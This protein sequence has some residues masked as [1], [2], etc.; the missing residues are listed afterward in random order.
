MQKETQRVA[1][2]RIAFPG[3]EGTSVEKWWEMEAISAGSGLRKRRG[4]C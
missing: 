3:M 1:A 2:R 4:I